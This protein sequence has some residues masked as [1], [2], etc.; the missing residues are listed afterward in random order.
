VAA[1]LTHGLRAAAR[2]RGGGDYDPAMERPRDLKNLLILLVGGRGTEWETDEVRGELASMLA[3]DEPLLAEF[4]EYAAKLRA[5]LGH[6]P[7][8]R[9]DDRVWRD[10]ALFDRLSSREQR[11]VISAGVLAWYGI[12]TLGLL[13]L[14]RRWFA[15]R[16]P[17]YET[18][19]WIF[20]ARPGGRALFKGS[21]L[22]RA[23][24]HLVRFRI[25]RAFEYV[26]ASYNPIL[27]VLILRPVY[28]TAGGNRRPF[29]ATMVTFAITAVI[30]HPLWATL[31][32]TAV[33][34]LGG[35]ISPW[36]AENTNV[37]T[38]ENLIL[39]ALGIGF[40]LSIGFLIAVS[41]TARRLLGGG[42]PV[43]SSGSP[44]AGSSR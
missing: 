27:T 6:R 18:A 43:T 39:H 40:W 19:W 12:I 32:L 33:F 24:R 7:S 28:R 37:A 35:T 5:K 31:A 29:R 44:R 14:P 34:G 8:A 3:E 11:Q 1:A 25:L 26:W 13:R 41:K 30:V 4:A 16:N 17:F 36:I 20:R 10:G 38:R 9:L 22:R 15:R 42:P 23:M 2:L 21:L